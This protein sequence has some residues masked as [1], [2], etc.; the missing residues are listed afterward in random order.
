MA[1]QARLN[2]L[3]S[4]PKPIH[5]RSTL[6]SALPRPLLSIIGQKLPGR[7]DSSQCFI[8]G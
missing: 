6:G 2:H 7:G 3:D 4:A 1:V 8:V 5:D